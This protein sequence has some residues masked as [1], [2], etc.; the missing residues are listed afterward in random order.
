M[1]FKKELTELLNKNNIQTFEMSE[2][3]DSE[4]N[5]IKLDFDN[6]IKFCK[7]HSIDTIFY[8][9]TYVYPE[10]FIIDE[11]IIKNSNISTSE[12]IRK[13]IN[14]YN[15][16]V[17]ELDFSK[18]FCLDIYALYQGNIISSSEYTECEYYYVP[19]SLKLMQITDELSD[20][21][22][23]EKTM[24][25]QKR[26]AEREKLKNIIINDAE[27]HKCTNEKFRRAYINKIVKNN[28]QYYDLFYRNQGGQHDDI[29]PMIFVE[30]I[31]KEYKSL[32]S[33]D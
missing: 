33:Q 26:E 16:S 5:I 6:L 17:C 14:D 15:K 13:K 29:S 7:I 1:K 31:W 24:Q 2:N 8:Y 4:D 19:P 12:I 30:K 27:F 28:R 22:S 10:N 25:S 9:Y 11:D 20:I 23:Q 18:P 3:I 32:K 21:L